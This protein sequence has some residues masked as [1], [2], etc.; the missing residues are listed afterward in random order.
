MFGV[1]TGAGH[2]AVDVVLVS[3]RGA[4]GAD[5]TSGHPDFRIAKDETLHC[6]SARR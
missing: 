3:G 5:L 4:I 2:N 1:W 6:M